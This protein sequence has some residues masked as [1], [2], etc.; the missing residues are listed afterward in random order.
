MEQKKETRWK[1]LSDRVR[2]RWTGCYN[3]PKDCHQSIAYPGRPPDFQKCFSKLTY[4]MAAFEELDFNYDILEV[5]QHYGADG[6]SPPQG[7][8]YREC[9]FCRAACPSRDYF[10]DPESGLPLE[11]G[12]CESDPPL[13]EPWCVKV[14]ACD[15]L[16]YEQRESAAT[17]DPARP[18]AVQAGSD[19]LADKYG[20][21]ALMNCVARRSKSEKSP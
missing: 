20:M 10:K 19:A 13:A 11:C 15:A 14:C 1:A 17:E 21:P 4:A 16:T 5:T 9:C 6:F 8:E 3:C 2:N 12:M 7:K 18:D